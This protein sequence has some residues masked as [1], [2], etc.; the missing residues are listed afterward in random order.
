MIDPA[1][2]R[3][4]SDS[5]EL[6]A[7]WRVFHDFFVM[8]VKGENLTPEKEAQFLE[9]KSKIAMLHDSF[10]EALTHDQNIGQE[11]L[12][13]VS[14]AITLKHLHKQ[15]AADIKKMEIEWHESYLLLNETIG[16]L[17][18]KRNE[19]SNINEAQYRAQKAAGVAGQN[20]NAVLTSF[21][22]KAAV[23]TAV[24]LAATV[25]VQ[26]LGIYDYNQLG[27]I[28]AMKTPYR[29]GVKACRSFSPD[30]P[31]VTIAVGTRKDP[32]QWPVGLKAPETKGDPKDKMY[33]EHRLPAAITQLLD[34]STEYRKEVTSKEF[35]GEAQIHTFLMPTAS[36][37]RQVEDEWRKFTESPAAAHLRQSA[38]MVRDVNIIVI[39]TGAK[40]MIDAVADEVYK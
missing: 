23:I 30:I 31:W 5:K 20:I 15:S 36:D 29:V 3:Q 12:G 38:R 40:E 4:Y 34:K 26:M 35:K 6:L 39:A 18:D 25:G 1:V 17:E 28:P 32:G 22:F 14:R 16:A 11:V 37:A 10:M 7:L 13:I 9:L 24:V 21:W 19:L 8:G 33:R 27:K 2:E